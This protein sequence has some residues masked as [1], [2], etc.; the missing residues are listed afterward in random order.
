MGGEHL[1]DFDVDGDGRIS[2]EEFAI[3][4]QSFPQ[5]RLWGEVDTDRDGSLSRDEVL[6]YFLRCSQGPPP[7]PP[8]CFVGSS[9]L[10]P[11]ACSHCARTIWG[12]HRPGLKCRRICSGPGAAPAAAASPTPPP[13]GPPRSCRS[14]RMGSSM[15]TSRWGGGTWGSGPR[16]WGS[17]H[18]GSPPPAPFLWG[19]QGSGSP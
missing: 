17:P 3:V 13:Q 16:T 2:R 11:T 12:L 18:W 1:P 4:G 10:R 14:P 8:H 15:F 19:P 6:A 5:L 9:P 7:G